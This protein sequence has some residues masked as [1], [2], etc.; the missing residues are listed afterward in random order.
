[1][2]I[3][4]AIAGL[5]S[6]IMTGMGASAA[7]VATGLGATIA[8]AVGGALVGAAIGG[9]TSAIMGGDI[10]KGVLFGAVGGAVTGGI[11]GYLG[12]A[13][14][15]ASSMNVG[16]Q[17]ADGLA[18]SGYGQGLPTS[19]ITEVVREGTRSI[20]SQVARVGMDLAKN[21]GGD[22]I[23]GVAGGIMKGKEMDAMHGMKLEEMREASRLR[24]EEAKQG[25]A[26][27]AKYGGSGG[28]GSSAQKVPYMDIEKI[29]QQTEREKLAENRRQYNVG[30]DER[31]QARADLQKK[32]T[33]RV[34]LFRG[35]R[36]RGSE[37]D[38]ADNGGVYEARQEQA[39]AAVPGSQPLTGNVPA[40]AVGSDAL[41]Q[42]MEDTAL[43]NQMVKK[44]EE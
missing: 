25:A 26:L 36:G 31:Q 15:A 23:K 4:L 9:L 28:G 39:L 5:G 24:M 16:A 17:G 3:G 12:A 21:F 6:A 37:G 13:G 43:T 22:I 2:G 29:R 33:D 8:G 7:F 27:S 1:M 20:G 41:A 32:E 34:S 42:A 11:S 10:M 40:V 44:E 14:N 18:M 19:G 30:H 38:V 35:G